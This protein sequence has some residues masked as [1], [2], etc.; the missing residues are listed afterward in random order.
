MKANLTF[1]E[2]CTL[3][4][5]GHLAK[6]ID[7]QM[8]AIMRS[9]AAVTGEVLEN[10][11]GHAS[12]FVYAP[13]GSDPTESVKIMLGKLGIT[14]EKEPRDGEEEADADVPDA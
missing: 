9:V 10:D 12:D 1:E 2:F 5:L 3:V 14:Y 11:Y 6:E 4:G 8:T 13:E 7:K